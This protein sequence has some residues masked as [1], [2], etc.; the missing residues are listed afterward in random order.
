MPTR[1]VEESPV[2]PYRLRAACAGLLLLAT[3]LAAQ[4][5]KEIKYRENVTLKV[6]Q[7][8]VVYGY[9]GDCGQLPTSGQVELPTLQTGTL[10][11]GKAGVRN[12]KRCNGKTP[13]VEIIFTAT[14]PGREKFELQGDDITVRVKN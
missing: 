10:S 6:G 12:S 4:S 13:A 8:V 14:T 2:T 7:S 9:R 1:I 3:P 11:T 5:A